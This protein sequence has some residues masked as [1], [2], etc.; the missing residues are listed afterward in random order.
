MKHIV[1]IDFDI[2]MEPSIEWYNTKALMINWDNLKM[3]PIANSFQADLIHYH[4][5]TAWLINQTKKLRSD[6][7]IFIQNHSQLVDYIDSNEF[8]EITNIDHH[9]DI[10]Y[11][12]RS[13]ENN[14]CIGCSNW[15]GALFDKRILNK[16]SW[17]NNVNSDTYDLKSEYPTYIT[18]LANYD[19]NN[20][21]DPDLI[22]IC[23]SPEWVPPQYRV[24]FFTWIE[25]LSNIYNTHYD[26]N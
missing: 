26:L 6:Q 8:Y 25:I 19:L 15:V 1:T 5:L 17:L 7:I 11:V 12:D 21:K 23:L 13:E 9:H 10:G 4:R 14:C 16:Y 24:L 3:D 20:L 22:I 2:I 18:H